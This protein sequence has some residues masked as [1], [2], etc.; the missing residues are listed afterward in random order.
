MALPDSFIYELKQNNPIDSVMSSYVSLIKR[1]R[2]YVCLCP[3][4]SEKSA[5]CTL[6]PENDSFYCFGCGAGGDVITFI[7][8]IENLSY[9]EAVKF[10]ADRAGMSMPDEAKNNDFSRL[11]ARVL[12]MNRTAARYFYETLTKSPEGE[13]GRR[14]FAER[15]L[16]AETITNSLNEDR[17]VLSSR[18]LLLFSC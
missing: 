6:Y 8:K 17:K 4:H 7:M 2:N 18:S 5:S 12:E 3:F 15:Q 13:K 11:K 10:L 1:G 16:K 14:Y 9:I